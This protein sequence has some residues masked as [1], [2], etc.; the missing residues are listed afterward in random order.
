MK[1]SAW[2]L[3]NAWQRR[4]DRAHLV[5]YE[6]FV[7]RPRETLESLLDYLGLDSGDATVEAT[8]AAASQP[9]AAADAH[10]TA[11]S[12]EASIG[13]WQHGPERRAEGAP[14]RRR[15]GRRSRRSAT[16]SLMTETLIVA[17]SVAQRPAAGGHTWVF[18]QYL[19]GFRDLGWDVVL[20]DR[21]EPDMCI[22]R[23]GDPCP[24]ENSVNLALP[25]G[26]RRALRARRLVRAALRRWN[27]M[28][29]HVARRAAGAGVA[30]GPA[31]ERQRL[32]GRTRTSS[33]GASETRVPRHRPRLR[34]DVAGAGPAR[35]VRGPRLLRDGGREHRPARL[36]DPHWRHRLGDHAAAGRARSLAGP[37]ARRRGVHERRE[38][39]R[40]GGA[41]RL[42]RQDLRPARARVPQVRLAPEALVRQPSRSR[43]T[44]TRPTRP[45]PTCCARTAG[46]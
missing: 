22:D 40:P 26:R 41:G 28:S 27:E 12:P 45:T 17:G 43:S 32:R 42:P 11:A 2:A 6:D 34:P 5:R 16:H 36:R 24:L 33:G 7:L 20:L 46:R 30:V 19:L 15:C 3:A 23:N 35:P 9:D 29:R 1:N 10:R 8:L 18:L 37:G 14:A 31:A 39:A 38:L 21:L 4:S 13:R 25:G 44:S